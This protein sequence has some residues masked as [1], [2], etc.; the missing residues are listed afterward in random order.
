MNKKEIGLLSVPL[1]ISFL[2][3][4]IL[5]VCLGNIIKINNFD[6]ISNNYINFVSVLIGFLITTITIVIGFFDKN[7]IKI[8][9]KSKKEKILYINWISTI[10]FGIISILYTFYLV[11]IFDSTQNEINKINL[12]V[13]LF[14]TISFI[15]Y[16]IMSLIYFFG[17]AIS[18]MQENNIEEKEIPELDPN[19]IKN[20]NIK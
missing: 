11:A 2:V 20:P 5:Y 14:L 12:I 1:D 13:I 8:I 18:V 6:M 9:V 7:I 17:I 4:I 16:L 15:G 10:I 3:S 19:K